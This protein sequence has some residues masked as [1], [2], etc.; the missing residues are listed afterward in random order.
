MNQKERMEEEIK[1]KTPPGWGEFLRG[2]TYQSWDLK[3][4]SSSAGEE[5][6][7]ETITTGNSRMSKISGWKR[8]R[9]L[10]GLEGSGD[11]TRKREEASGVCCCK[12]G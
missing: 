7:R 5:I 2:G 8:T 3:M 1:M 10:G 12:Y 6:W 9:R 11:G 4:S